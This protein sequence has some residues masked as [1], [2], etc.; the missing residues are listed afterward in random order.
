MWAL[1]DTN[2]EVVRREVLGIIGKSGVRK[3][4][5]LKMLSRIT[6]PT[7]GTIKTRG[8]IASLLEVGTGFHGE[9]TGR[10]NIF[11]STHNAL[12]LLNRRS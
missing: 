2:F 4:T 1:Q 10:E 6:S 12:I 5:L 7:A 11:N 9:M 3:S 8:R